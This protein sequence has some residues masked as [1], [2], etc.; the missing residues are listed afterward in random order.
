MAP[1]EVLHALDKESSGLEVKNT[2]LH[3]PTDD[4]DDSDWIVRRQASEPAPKRQLSDMRVVS[5]YHAALAKCDEGSDETSD[6]TEIGIEDSAGL[7][8]QVSRPETST[9]DDL[10][11]H[12]F[13]TVD[14]LPEMEFGT[15]DALPE[16]D[17]FS[18]D[19]MDRQASNW[20]V[21]GS[22]LC[23][24]ETEM[25]WPAYKVPSTLD[26]TAA[27]FVMPETSSAQSENDDTS[28]I[29]K[30]GDVLPLTELVPEPSATLPPWPMNNNMMLQA[31]M[32]NSAMGMSMCGSM[33]EPATSLSAQPYMKN[34]RKARSLITLA[35]EQQKKQQSILWAQKVQLLKQHVA[36]Q[37]QPQ[38]LE[39]GREDE[40]MQQQLMQELA[41]NAKNFAS[42]TSEAEP[43]MSMASSKQ[44]QDSRSSSKEASS[45]S[46]S[47]CHDPVTK[48]AEA[49]FCPYC[50]GKVQ[51]RFKF[52]RFCGNDVSQ[53]WA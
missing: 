50:G 38:L 29:H 13:G 34:R 27:S 31:M 39:G 14:A 49:Q 17:D 48:K 1:A 51:Q 15:V 46:A 28:T 47:V 10:P 8:R 52:C 41:E 19:E 20:T 4:L 43:A 23:R 26:A 21:R 30:K 40:R 45:V 35:Q 53:L 11:E 18:D 44:M 2:F 3:C 12:E 25:A 32:W 22:G 24:Q 7:F 33:D 6:G 16:I 9:M 5:P 37:P 36:V 42:A